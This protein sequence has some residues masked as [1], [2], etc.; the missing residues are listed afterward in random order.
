[1]RDPEAADSS[2]STPEALSVEHTSSSSSSDVSPSVEGA[3][4]DTILSDGVLGKR[5]SLITADGKKGPLVF[6]WMP[7]TQNRSFFLASLCWSSNV[8]GN[9]PLEM[10]KPAARNIRRHTEQ[11]LK[12]H[13]EVEGTKHAAWLR[14]KSCDERDGETD[15]PHLGARHLTSLAD[16]VAEEDGDWSGVALKPA[17]D[18]GETA[19]DKPF[20]TI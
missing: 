9:D 19:G 4:R 12:S 1:M 16:D 17:V 13:D 2:V 6:F 11:S 15:P 10:L 7:L 8:A 20:F 18:L 14:Q 3:G 5:K